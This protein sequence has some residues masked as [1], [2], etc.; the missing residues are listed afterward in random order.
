MKS[1]FFERRKILKGINSLDLTPVKLV[2]S[3]MNDNGRV[4]ILLPR[5]KSTF[6]KRAL[7]SKRKGEFIRI[8][9]DE[10]GSL[11]WSNIN[12]S[13]KVHDLCRELTRS[14]PEKLN[15]PE[16]TEERVSKFLSLLYQ[17]RYIT[18]RELS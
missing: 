15:P 13:T 16:E 11:I 3:E 8:H 10:V 5:F 4:D 7:Q 18:F 2:G 6:V 14:H 9:L 1:G 12:G 17:E